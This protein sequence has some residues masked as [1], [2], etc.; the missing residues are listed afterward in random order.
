ME[1]FFPCKM[2][3]ASAERRLVEL[4]RWRWAGSCLAVVMAFTIPN[5][6][7]CRQNGSLKHLVSST[8][9]S[10]LAEKRKG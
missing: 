4:V 6:S 10:L 1:S 9:V 5:Q 2:L 7:C 8:I 3:G